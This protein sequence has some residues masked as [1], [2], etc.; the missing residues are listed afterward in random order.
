MAS[1]FGKR[2]L[3]DLASGISTE[4]IQ[5]KLD[6]VRRWHQDYHH[7]S[8][9]A[10]KETSREQAYNSDFFIRILGYKDKP[11][12]PFTF[13]PKATTEKKQ[14]PDAVLSYTDTSANIA[15][16]SAVIELKGAATA[17]DRPQRR[18][19]N[20]SPVQ[21]GFKYK[22]QY[23]TCPFVVVSNFYEFRL[24]NDNQLDFETWTLDDLVNPD[25][26]YYAFK[27]WYGLLR[28]ENLVSARGP[29]KTE[30]L[31]SHFRIEQE[32]IGKQ[33]YAKYKDARLELLRDIYRLN[34]DLRTEFDVAIQMGQKIV[35]RV[36]F[37]CFAEDR[38][39]L[40]ENVIASVQRDADSSAYASLWMMLKSLFNAID[41]GSD[42][43]GIP[44]GYNGGLFAHDPV[45]DGL[46]ISDETL[47][48]VLGLSNYNFEE[49]LSV[50]ILGHIFEQSI[51]DLE[52]IRSKVQSK[53]EADGQPADALDELVRRD[54]IT[55]KRKSE[56]VYY[57]PDYIV[58]YIVDNTLGTF[59]KDKEQA[60]IEE[61]ELSKRR[62][63]KTY[64]ESEVR[65]YKQYQYVLQN[66]KVVDPACG[67]G[68]FLVYALDYLLRE[69]E[70]VVAI[71]GEED[72]F[73]VDY[74][75]DSILR[76]NLFG[77]DINDES[78]EITKLSLWLKTATAGKKLTSLDDNI[79]CGNSLVADKRVDQD[80]GFSYEL[81]F[82]EVFKAGGFDVVFGNPPY[83]SA[84]ELSRSMPEVERKYLKKNY[85]TSKGSV[86]LYIYFF[87]KGMKLLKNGGRLGFI[88]PNRYLSASYGKTLRSWLVNNY[89]FS[90]LLDYSDKTVFEDAS[91]YPVISILR[92]LPPGDGYSLFAGNIDEETK[93]PALREFDS[94][95]LSILNEHILG[96]LLN[97]KIDITEKVFQQGVSL[98]KS[99]VINATSTAGEADDYSPLIVE[100]DTLGP[101]MINTGT[102]DPY[103]STWGY[104]P[105]TNQ[106]QTFMR[107]RL[108]VNNSIV[109]ANRRALYSSRKIIISKIGKTCEAFYDAEGEY[110]S[111]NTNCIHSFSPE[112]LPE[113]VL[114]WLNSKLYNYAF[115]CLF[116]GLRM[117][118]GYLLYSAP[119][120]KNT[121]IKQISLDEQQLFVELGQKL[122]ELHRSLIKTDTRF[123]TFAREEA[124]IA[125]WPRKFN[126]WWEVDYFDLLKGLKSKMS[127]QK[128]DEL[129]EYFDGYQTKMKEIVET[130]VS[131]QARVDAKFYSM[132]GLSEDEIQR[133][134]KSFPA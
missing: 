107:P 99:G 105:L 124:G 87:E 20:M 91:T 36:V 34:P 8:L 26:D 19:G 55:G 81:A 51:T 109:S 25:E 12:T 117:N 28:S 113:Y 115:E 46:K 54:K 131:V 112:Y 24:Y 78:V 45:L 103:V 22:T 2:K 53:V 104:E 6:I 3:K 72:F 95:R 85:E 57:T 43:L 48:G 60:L 76:Q 50:N 9:K 27:T 86:D 122:T 93:R 16:I 66:V 84:M 65:A 7:G 79:K 74:W 83:V 132:H 71:L 15:N 11:A 108:D 134:E 1:I 38:G 133:V 70:R 42:N 90:T 118:G 31:L 73:T 68:A 13:E 37:S 56:G 125:A 61:H 111:I 32:A 114:C 80:K 41:N 110:A 94:S 120:L 18:E 30:Q 98:S 52:E 39:L 49:D 58:R 75:I 29:S 23:R 4:E 100:T 17:L 129:Q 21:Q 116:D 92:K 5:D 64:R 101:K 106:G 14:L 88:S 89:R 128:K 35:D 126:R 67:S 123:K 69:N 97:D 44:I 33:F 96:F 102:I 82:P 130:V 10:D 63:E 119:N 47:N 59:L 121:P 127:V 62:N 77:V 40:P